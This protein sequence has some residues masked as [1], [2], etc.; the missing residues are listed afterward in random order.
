MNS[1]PV[2]RGGLLAPA[3]TRVVRPVLPDVLSGVHFAIA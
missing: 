3:D 1:V 2:R